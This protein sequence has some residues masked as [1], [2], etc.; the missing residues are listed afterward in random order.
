VTDGV[1]NAALG[2]ATRDAAVIADAL[3]GR[4]SGDGWLARCPAHDDA[5]PSLG[6]VE[7]DGRVLVCCRAGCTQADVLAAL[8]ERGLWPSE[9]HEPGALG[10]RAR[11]RRDRER[12]VRA[13][14][15]AWHVAL[16][17]LCDA[18]VGVD[19]VRALVRHDVEERDPRTTAALDALGDPYLR[20]QVAEQ[21]LDEIERED[22]ALR[23]GVRHVAA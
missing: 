3:G 1:R 5:H 17:E 22:R 2:Y 13:L 12:Q 9:R 20:E 16:G 18:R 11:E 23:G 6:I 14:G 8:R 4:R 10:R 21:A 7:R 19:L 15:R